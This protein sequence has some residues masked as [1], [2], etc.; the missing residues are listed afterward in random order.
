MKTIISCGSNPLPIIVDDDVY[1]WASQYKWILCG[2]YPRRFYGGGKSIQLT[3]EMFGLKPDDKREV[4]HINRDI[5]DNRWENLRLASRREN[6]RNQKVENREAKHS[7][8][9][10]VTFLKRDGYWQAQTTFNGKSKYIGIFKD[11]L[12]AARAYD[13]FAIKNYGEFARLNFA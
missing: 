3:R 13:E 8:F 2:G 9:K 12:D 6:A 10:G 11:E 1:E 7:K 5:L 4:D